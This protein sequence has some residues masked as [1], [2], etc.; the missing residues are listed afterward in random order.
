MSNEKPE[1]DIEKP[2]A[3]LQGYLDDLLTVST[4]LN[5][6]AGLD[7]VA[8]REPPA[9][10]TAVVL[11]PEREVRRYQD[12][13]RPHWAQQQFDAIIICSGGHHFAVPL[14]EL[15]SLSLLDE[16]ESQL[17]TETTSALVVSERATGRFRIAHLGRLLLLEDYQG[18]IDERQ[19]YLLSLNGENWGL[20]VASVS[21]RLSIDPDAVHWRMDRGKNPW[22]AGTLF[23]SQYP[24][25]D[26]RQLQP[27]L[28]RLSS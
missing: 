6:V 5:M 23:E 7:Y 26:L 19:A 9:S 17:F 2:G 1:L 10:A 16:F 12:A 4:S 22:L 13:N 28:K 18:A 25:L 21:D 24:L 27:M 8:E 14:Q 3:V 20:A 15:A 11:E